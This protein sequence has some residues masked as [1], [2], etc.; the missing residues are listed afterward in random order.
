[1]LTAI[2]EISEQVR[3]LQASQDAMKHSMKHSM[4]ASQ[5]IKQGERG[6]G[7][8]EYTPYDTSQPLAHPSHPQQQQP[9]LTEPT[10]ANA[11]NDWHAS[12]SSPLSVRGVLPSPREQ[13]VE[14]AQ[15]WR[16]HD[17]YEYGGESD[18]TAAA[19]AAA[20]AGDAASEHVSMMRPA[21]LRAPAPLIPLIPDFEQSYESAYNRPP[22]PQPLPHD[23][24]VHPGRHD[25]L[26][27]EHSSLESLGIPVA[28]H[29][30]MAGKTSYTRTV[31]PS[32]MAL[33]SAEK[34]GRGRLTNF[35]HVSQVSGG[36]PP[37]ERGRGAN[38]FQAGNE[39]T[40]M[41]SPIG[42]GTPRE[43][44][45]HHMQQPTSTSPISEM[46]RKAVSLAERRPSQWEASLQSLET[47]G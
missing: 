2:S 17:T 33:S 18:M 40:H 43:S 11:S 27:S 13:E 32:P 44:A 28:N 30:A 25:L 45:V 21:S 42:E 23:G 31:R 5:H 8:T 22:L 41:M 46:V 29:T 14:G 7:S 19:A 1:M 10:Y 9:E 26:Q 20:A 36:Q 35:N 39:P 38:R 24:G 3:S 6:G 37:V 15:P 34:R 47:M 16:L 4:E 12:Q